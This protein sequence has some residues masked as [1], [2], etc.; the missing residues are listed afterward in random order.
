MYFPK[1]LQTTILNTLT[2]ENANT[3]TEE[4]YIFMP[5]NINQI[6][7]IDGIFSP[8]GIYRK[9]GDLGGFGHPGINVPLVAGAEIYAAQ[10]GTI[11]FI[12]RATDN[13]PG[14]NVKIIFEGN[15]KGEGWGFYYEHINQLENVKVGSK[16]TKGQL[17]AKNALGKYANSH[18]RLSYWYNDY[19]YSKDAKCW[20][21]EL[22]TTDKIAFESF[23]K[24]QS[25]MAYFIEAWNTVQEEGKLTYKGLLDKSRFPTGPQLCYPPGTDGRITL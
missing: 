4:N 9:T 22:S 20:V 8:F 2:N 5:F 1:T 3:D 25:E 23:F 10:K 19:E 15:K 12:E 16:V 21:N 24:K 6:D 17:I 13:R 18:F 14:Y 11:I 7:T